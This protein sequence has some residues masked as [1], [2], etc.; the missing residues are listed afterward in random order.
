MIR[1]I[2]FFIICLLF[3][4]K[5]WAQDPWMITTNK[6]ETNNYFGIT[7]ANGI[8]GLVSSPSPLQIEHVVLGGVYDIY[9]KGRVSNFLPGINMLNTELKINGKIVNASNISNFVQTLNMKNA[10]FSAS[11]DVDNLA[12]VEYSYMALRHL[13]YSCLL[14]VK[15]IPQADI[16]IDVANIQS[17]SESFRNPQ[18][19]FNRITNGKMKFDV[20]TSIADSPTGAIIMGACSSF[21]FDWRQPLP[22][23]NH[24]SRRGVGNH[25]QEF[26][27]NLSVGNPYVFSI[28][29]TTLSS[30]THADVRNEVERMNIYAVLEGTERLLKRHNAAWSEI[31]ESDIMIEGDMQSQQDIHSML[32]HLY[33][34]NREGS[35]LSCS[36]MGLSGLG[37]NGHVF[38][39]ADTWMFPALVLL[40]PKI[41]ESMIEYRYRRLDAAQNNAFMHGY[42]GAMFP[43]ESSASGGEE[44]TVHN[45]YGPFE[46][47]ITGDVAVATWQYFCVTQD[48]DWLRTKGYPILSATA[49]FWVS[50]SEKNE[51]GNYEIR[52]VIGADEW[53]KNL[54]GGKNVNN[55][56]YTNGVAKTNLEIAFKAAKVLGMKP[57]AQWQEVANKLIFRK[58]YNGVTA[59][60]DTYNGEITK[61][62]DVCLLAFPLNIITDKAQIKKDLDYYVQTVPEKKTPAMSKSVFSILYTR[63]ADPEKAW[64]Y[65][66]DAYE[67]NLNPPFRV[68][69]EF[70]GGTN[71]YFIT[72][73]GGVLQTLLMGFGGLEIT[74]KGIVINKGTLP[75]QW[76]S[77]TIKG[78]GLDKKTYKITK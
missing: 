30:V 3:V 52:N 72:G 59:E 19:Y 63:L 14:S 32:Y 40:N 55:N 44:N 22:D 65:F 67:P 27:V 48:M 41:A 70:N 73:A 47:H 45:I 57:E 10:V 7:S 5:I 51:D 26:S 76:Q 16:S 4:S 61:Q 9:G 8:L 62:A 64:F 74:D 24:L 58:M 18:D 39:D 31:W 56:A 68:I 28:V 21:I 78:I 25:T 60:H 36:P 69:A 49:D 33:A 46:N 13:P 37:Y 17:I 54:D 15:I 71:P 23:I 43:W 42:A 50:R 2:Y 6:I 38:W 75:T 34:F 11:F 29:G 53:N 66:K 35:G 77:L 20:M 12:H 1:N